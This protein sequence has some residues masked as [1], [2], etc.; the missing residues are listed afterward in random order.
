[1]SSRMS[2]QLVEYFKNLSKKTINEAS[3][4]LLNEFYEILNE[5]KKEKE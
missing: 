4:E 2:K 1:M 5:D 3:K